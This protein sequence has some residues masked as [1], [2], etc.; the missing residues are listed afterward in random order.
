MSY[1]VIIPAYNEEKSIRSVLI[2]MTEALNKFE[3]PFEIIVVN[4]GS[5]D[6]TKE[7]VIASGIPVTIIDHAKN[8]GYGAAIKTGLKKSI[9]DIIA[10]TDAD[11]TYPVKMIPEFVSISVNNNKDMVVGARTSSDVHIPIVRR[12]AKWIIN[13]LA[14]YLTGNN[15]PDLNSGLRVIRKSI[16]KKYISLL[17]N[18]FSL[19]TTLTLIMIS[20]GFSINYLPISYS[21]RIGKSKIRPIHDTLN[22]IQLIIR[23]TLYFNPL[24][25]FIP[26]SLLLILLA[27]LVLLGSW[28]I[29]DRAM[30]VT[31]GVIMMTSVIVLAI[32]MLADLIDKRLQ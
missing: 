32:G 23:I 25:I 21:K 2:E 3:L 31:F 30:D 16:I 28:L 14:N 22:F 13:K 20:N 26:M 29:F 5:I 6:K 24:K 17:P 27:I 11:G 8:M 12:P 10:I 4:D 9:F 18:G 1:S 15:I 7:E 19:T